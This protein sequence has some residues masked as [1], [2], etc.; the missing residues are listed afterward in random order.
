MTTAAPKPKLKCEVLER[1][2]AM[3]ITGSGKSYQWLKIAEQLMPTGAVFRVIDTDKDI[4]YMMRTQFK[5][6]LPVN[7][8]NVYVH[9]AFDW[10]EYKRGVKWITGKMTDEQKASLQAEHPDLL[11]VYPGFRPIQPYDFV[12]VDKVN[13]AWK[14]VTN[15]FVTNVFGDDPGDYFLMIRKEIQDGI[16]K[17]KGGKQ[18]E[19]T[20]T[21]GLDGWKDW[22]VINKLYDDWILPIIYQVNC[23]VYCATDVDALDKKTKDAEML[24]LFGDVGVKPAGQKSLGGQHHSIFLF[25]PGAM[26]SGRWYIT[27]I[28]DRAGRNYFDK[29]PMASFFYQYLV[30]K[31]QWSIE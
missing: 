5:H 26:G 13:N 2:L 1:I 18:P 16:R 20:I 17:A 27:T 29:T 24:R 10:S 4:D 8:G 23:H 9:P 28:K 6:L 14:T 15:Y 25:L 11:K 19:S 3:G 30:A 22:S 12:V 31:A 7:G 21:E